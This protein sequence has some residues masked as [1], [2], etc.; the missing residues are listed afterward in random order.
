MRLS[1]RRFIPLIPLTVLVIPLELRSQE[2]IVVPP[3]EVRDH[4]LTDALLEQAAPVEVQD[5]PADLDAPTGPAREASMAPAVLLRESGGVGQPMGLGIRGVDPQGTLAAL[6]GVP[7]NSPFLGGTDLSGLGLLPLVRLQITRGGQSAV[8]GSDAMGGV[9]D[10]RTP[11]PLDEPG[12]QGSL[13]VGSFGTARL[14]ASYG[15]RSGRWGGLAAIGLLTSSGN[16]GFTDSNGRERVRSNNASTAADLLFKVAVEP[17]TGHVLSLLVEGFADDRD[18]PGLE[19]FPSRT[20]MQRDQRVIAALDYRGPSLLTP[21]GVTRGRLYFR[22]LGFAYDDEAPPMGAPVFARLLSWEIGGEASGMERPHRRFGVPWGISATYTRGTVRRTSQTS[23]SPWRATVSARTGVH[24]GSPRDPY[25]VDVTLRGEYDQG[26]GWRFVPR[27]GAWYRPVKL[28]KLFANVGHAF[29]LPTFE[30][31]YF[32]AG[33][34]QGNPDLDPEDAITWDV[35]F[36]LGIKDV[37]EFRAAYFENRVENLIQ[38]LP[39]SA[40]LIRAENSDTAVIRGLEAQ[41]KAIVGPVIIRGSYT[42][43]YAR[44]GSGTTL[45]H[46]PQHAGAGEVVFEKGWIRIGARVRGQSAFYLDRYESL[47]EEFRAIL[48]ARIELIPHPYVT[49]SLDVHNLLDK[50]DAIDTLQYPLPG[51]AFYGTLRFFL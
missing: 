49:L 26:F 47:S 19:Q 48:D 46:R 20:A 32:E 42:Y 43:L 36:T 25:G 40:F 29:R 17:A 21:G 6:D 13:T 14:K 24:V 5:D 41:V 4:A 12:A 8:R 50:R 35:G 31:L 18:I 10:A 22:W 7:L 23:L 30:E 45:P 16:F 37:A 15:G 27:A 44:Y 1:L 9:L 11:N 2:P 3:V 28:L 38:F 33:F 39:Q 51:R 34:V